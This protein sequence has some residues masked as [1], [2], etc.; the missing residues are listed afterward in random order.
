MGHRRL[1]GFAL[2]TA[3]LA[4]V[5]LPTTA[6]AQED[7]P[8]AVPVTVRALEPGAL[9]DQPTSAAAAPSTGDVA[10]TS[11]PDVEPVLGAPEPQIIIGPDTRTK[12]TQTNQFPGSAVTLITVDP[13]DP[14][15]GFSCTGWLISNDTVATAAH[16]VVYD[17]D[18]AF[19][20]VFPGWDGDSGAAES[21]GIVEP[22]APNSWLNAGGDGPA[23][24]DYAA[25]KLDASLC[26]DYSDL[27]HFGFRQVADSKIKGLKET[28]DGYPS[29]KNGEQ[30]RSTGKIRRAN[31]NL[32]F[33]KNDTF[34]GNSGSPVYKTFN[35]CGTCAVA[36]HTSSFGGVDPENGGTRIRPKVGRFLNRVVDEPFPD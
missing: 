33:Y 29:D 8:A 1:L 27:G 35:N 22:F 34:A 11:S 18:G 21:C 23:R 10:P 14:G 5:L 32:V 15:P 24:D 28:L 4:A 26:A 6:D 31:K 19:Y 30:W 36:I 17:E 16:C 2:G 9:K 25:L 12:V 13:V 20:N 7:A 3:L